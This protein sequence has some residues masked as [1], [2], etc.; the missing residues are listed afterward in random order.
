MRYLPIEMG[1]SQIISLYNLVSRTR[2]FQ[3]NQCSVISLTLSIHIRYFSSR[4]I[5]LTSASKSA[6][7]LRRFAANLRVFRFVYILRF[8]SSEPGNLL[9]LNS[10]YIT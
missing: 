9:S 8:L 1:K 4:L 7:S 5:Y 2:D 3:S 6:K 10:N